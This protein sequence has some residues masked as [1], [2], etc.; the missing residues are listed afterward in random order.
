MKQ[1]STER[2][3]AYHL[4][5]LHRQFSSGE[6]DEDNVENADEAHFIISMENGKD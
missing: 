6:L 5:M 4:G 2:E 1:E 3:V